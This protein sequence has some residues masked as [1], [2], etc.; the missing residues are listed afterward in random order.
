MKRKIGGLE[1]K[2]SELLNEKREQKERIEE[3]EKEREKERKVME[4]IIERKDIELRK[5]R[6]ELVELKVGDEDGRYECGQC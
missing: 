1:G 5:V 6:K 4:G 3:M 2:T